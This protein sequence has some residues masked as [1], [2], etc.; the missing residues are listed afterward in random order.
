MSEPNWQV[1]GRHR[2]SP[3]QRRRDRRR[4]LGMVALLLATLAIGAALLPLKPHGIVW[5]EEFVRTGKVGT[6]VDARAFDIT[7]LDATGGA[8]ID[9]K[10]PIETNG[11]WIVVRIRVVAKD[12]PVTIGYAA[13]RDDQGRVYDDADKVNQPMIGGR[14]LQPG[15]PVEGQ[16]VFEV[17]RD[18]RRLT[19]RFAK[20]ALFQMYD[21]VAE[22]PLPITR[23]DIDSWVA[24]KR[25]VPVASPKA[26]G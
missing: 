11:I 3:E 25:A 21:A 20:P 19:A 6:P 8:K 4:K 23:A 9:A 5:Q 18:V 16:V 1:V 26:V 15:V 14:A 12:K 2:P 22:I 24:E 7:V 13:L 17:A 10:T